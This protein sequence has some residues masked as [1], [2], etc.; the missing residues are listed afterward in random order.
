MVAALTCRAWL[1]PALDL[2]WNVDLVDILEV[3]SPMTVDPNVKLV[4]VS[5][6]HLRARHVSELVREG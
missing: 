2:L 1:D 4:S 3:L 5:R 6:V